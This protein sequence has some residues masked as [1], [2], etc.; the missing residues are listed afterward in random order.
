MVAQKFHR[1]FS[2][3]HYQSLADVATLTLRA[4]YRQFLNANDPVEAAKQVKE[5]LPTEVLI[6]TLSEGDASVIAVSLS[7]FVTRSLS[8]SDTH[9]HTQFM[10]FLTANV[11]RDEWQ[12]R[13][14]AYTVTCSLLRGQFHSQQVLKRVL[15]ETLLRHH[16]DM[17]SRDSPLPLRVAASSVILPVAMSH[18]ELVAH[19]PLLDQLLKLVNTSL[20]HCME[21]VADGKNVMVYVEMLLTIVYHL[22]SV[23]EMD[24][25][26]EYFARVS[27][28]DLAQ[29]LLQLA[30]LQVVDVEGGW[31]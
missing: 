4:F 12:D 21:D 14:A 27:L 5:Q 19:T 26:E 13:A 31:R 8:L 2:P 1:M 11:S 6:A 16:N 25:V 17:T 29:L 10:P 23:A 3:A 18:A 20:R 24:A 28:A 22:L 7:L 15:D 9:A 30:Y